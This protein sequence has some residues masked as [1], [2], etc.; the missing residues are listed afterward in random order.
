MSTA[1]SASSN[2]SGWGT[3]QT[4]P[5][6]TYTVLPRDLGRQ[7]TCSTQANGSVAATSAPVTA[8]GPRNTA[9]PQVSGDLRIGRVLTCD[10]G[11]WDDA[12]RPYQF[13]Y[14]WSVYGWGFD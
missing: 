3:V 7:V 11:T 8:N 6:T 12:G 10:P 4:G 14:T 2:V 1:E 9:L 13:K 5:Q